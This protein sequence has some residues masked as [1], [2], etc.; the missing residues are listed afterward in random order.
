MAA[1]LAATTMLPARAS[2]QTASD[3]WRTVAP[4]NLLVIE[5]SK[6]RMLAE[7]TPWA[8]PQAVARVRTLADQGFYDGLTFHRVIRGFMAQTGDPE[9]TGQGG[10]DLPDLPGEFSFRRG[11][12]APLTPVAP[13]APTAGPAVTGFVGSLPVVSQPDAQMFVTADNRVDSLARFCPGVLG[14]ARTQDPNSANSQWFVMTGVNP[15]LDGGYTVF[16]RVI[17]GLAAAEALKAGSE[18]ADGRVSDDPD[19]LVRVRTAA[20]MPAGDRPSGRVLD[21][22]SPRFAEAVA[23]ARA[24]KGAAFSVCD[25]QPVSEITGG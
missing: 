11:M 8:A 19:T 4:E 20:S 10:S 17:D 18:E 23:A 24:E 3:G 21:P 2:A 1:V 13:G 15:R 7:L 14:M 12:D 22:A 9:G 25:V 16:G 6:G 5:T